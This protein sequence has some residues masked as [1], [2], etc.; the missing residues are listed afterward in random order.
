MR[1]EQISW[2]IPELP[3]CVLD[4]RTFVSKK[5][6]FTSCPTAQLQVPHFPGKKLFEVVLGLDYLSFGENYQSSWV[7]FPYVSLFNDLNESMRSLS[8][9]KV[10]FLQF[11]LYTFDET[12][13]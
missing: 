2:R 13:C 9:T 6:I 3:I 11:I 5:G 12:Y 7:W 4:G 1:G 8:F 10:H